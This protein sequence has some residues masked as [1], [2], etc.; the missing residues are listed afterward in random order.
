MVEHLNDVVHAINTTEGCR[1]YVRDAEG[2]AQLR[3]FAYGS[4]TRWNYWIDVADRLQPAT[5]RY[6]LIL[7]F[8]LHSWLVVEGKDGLTLPAQARLTTAATTYS[9]HPSCS[10]VTSWQKRLGSS[11][12]K[13]ES[14]CWRKCAIRSSEFV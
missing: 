8:L 2:L 1:E 4:N 11:G 3:Q 5:Q 9:L 12:T 14:S 6:D 7:M 13:D 10:A